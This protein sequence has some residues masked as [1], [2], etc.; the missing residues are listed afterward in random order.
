MAEPPDLT[1]A[2]SK[3]KD[4]T[5]AVKE[6]TLEAQRLQ[7]NLNRVHKLQAHLLVIGQHWM[8]WMERS[9]QL[10]CAGDDSSNKR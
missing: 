3:V 2:R 9:K 5:A 10:Q 8:Q 7:N 6:L 4:L 1:T